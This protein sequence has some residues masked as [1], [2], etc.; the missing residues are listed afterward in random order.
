MLLISLHP[1]HSQ[2]ILAGKKTIE[3]R[4]KPPRFT[5]EGDEFIFLFN[6][7]L[8]YETL[9]TAA[10]VGY[11]SPVKLMSFTAKEWHR[12]SKKLC[13]SEEEISSYLG[14]R[15]GY[16]IVIQNPVR[17]EPIPLSKMRELGILPPQSYQYLNKYWS[18]ILLAD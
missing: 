17:I 9:P 13:L 18:S 8:I 3:L 10:I 14:D 12:Y 11:V 1:R 5:Q 16:G 15:I 6:K 7:I 2:N 4:K